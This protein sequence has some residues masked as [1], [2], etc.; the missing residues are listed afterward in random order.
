MTDIIS[1]DIKKEIDVE[2]SYKV[3]YE[4]YYKNKREIGTSQFLN[5]T[6]SFY[7]VMLKNLKLMQLNEN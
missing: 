2:E 6:F 7:L 1:V 5:Q 3:D 4:G